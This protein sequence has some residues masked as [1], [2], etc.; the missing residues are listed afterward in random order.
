[1]P[2]ISTIDCNHDTSE[3]TPLK[4][5][6]YDTLES[7]DYIQRM[8]QFQLKLIEALTNEDIQRTELTDEAENM[9]S[10]TEVTAA[11]GEPNQKKITTVEIVKP[12]T[13]LTDLA[14][15]IIMIT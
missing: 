1:M 4:S 5:E 11:Q 14:E 9:I 2:S 15:I 8:G 7:P 6:Y 10:L 13:E 3:T 12:K